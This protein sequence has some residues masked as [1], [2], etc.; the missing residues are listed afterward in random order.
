MAFIGATPTPIPLTATD[1]PDLPATK[2]TSGTLADA[3]FPATLPPLNGSNLTNLDASDLTG[4]LPAIS[5]ANLTGITSGGLV[6]IQ[7]S[8]LGS[9][10]AQMDFSNVFSTTYKSYLFVF[11]TLISTGTSDYFICRFFSDT[12]TTV[13]SSS[14]YEIVCPNGRASSG[15]DGINGGRSWGLSYFRPAQEVFHSA[16][17][18]SGHMFI[19]DPRNSSERSTV[20]GLFGAYDG[21]Q[22]RV[23]M[24]WGMAA[25]TSQWYGMRFLTTSS[26]LGSGT[27][28]SLYGVANS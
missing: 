17:P 24:F 25:T 19:H 18:G 3:R 2:I 16:T 22:H 27:S 4:T 23:S 14:N 1:I 7:T 13:H 9:D 21:S 15:G 26:N 11:N 5:G 20:E 6:H 12:G 10:T 8:T 28:I